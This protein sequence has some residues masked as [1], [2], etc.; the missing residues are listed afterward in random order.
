M[1]YLETKLRESDIFPDP[2]K[3]CV[4]E[5]QQTEKRDII[6]DHSSYSFSCNFCTVRSSLKY[7]NLIS[8]LEMLDSYIYTIWM[9]KYN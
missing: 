8:K 1:P 3:N 4:D 6:D 5:G 7:V 9:G 2:E